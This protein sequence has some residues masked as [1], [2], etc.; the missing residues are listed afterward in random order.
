M[1]RN[2]TPVAPV[3]FSIFNF[4][5][6]FLNQLISLFQVTGEQFL[7]IVSFSSTVGRAAA[8]CT[9]KVQLQRAAASRTGW[10]QLQRAARQQRA[11]KVQLPRAA[12]QQRAAVLQPGRVRAG[13]VHRALNSSGSQTPTLY[14]IFTFQLQ[15]RI[16][17]TFKSLNSQ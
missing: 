15:Y 16:S 12:R 13:L 6:L 14:F 5:C 2:E 10:V 8:Q 17:V 4:P 9:G 1:L 7:N 3:W 11:G